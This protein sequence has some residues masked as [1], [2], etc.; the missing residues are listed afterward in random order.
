MELHLVIFTEA[1]RES[2]DR[3]RIRTNVLAEL[4][5]EEAVKADIRVGELTLVLCLRVREGG[6]ERRQERLLL[7]ERGLHLNRLGNRA[8]PR[9]DL[10]LRRRIG[11]YDCTLDGTA[12]V[13][14]IHVGLLSALGSLLEALGVY[15]ACLRADRCL[16]GAQSTGSR[17]TLVKELEFRECLSNTHNNHW[18]CF[19]L[20]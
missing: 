18:G 19:L 13:K 11:L 12:A 5:G 1:V 16:G 4:A 2:R 14:K 7:A 6:A 10:H 15:G 17:E 9:A 3:L 20:G 8:L